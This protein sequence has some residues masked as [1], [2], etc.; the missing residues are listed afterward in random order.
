[1]CV[2]NDGGILMRRNLR[3]SCL[4]RVMAHKMAGTRHLHYQGIE[5]RTIEKHVG[6]VA[7]NQCSNASENSTVDHGIEVEFCVLSN[8]CSGD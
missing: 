5:F 2:W 6:N 4:I 3:I 7:A 1:M 8:F